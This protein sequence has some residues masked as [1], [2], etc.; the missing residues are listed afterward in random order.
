MRSVQPGPQFLPSDSIKIE[1]GQE[2]SLP[3]D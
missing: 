1:A 2:S 3:E